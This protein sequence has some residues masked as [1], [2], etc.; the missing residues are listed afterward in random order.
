MLKR[1]LEN[2]DYSF[3]EIGAIL[4]SVGFSNVNY[5]IEGKEIVTNALAFNTRGRNILEDSVEKFYFGNRG[6]LRHFYKGFQISVKYYFYKKAKDKVSFQKKDH[7][8][9]ITESFQ[10]FQL[11]MDEGKIDLKVCNKNKSFNFQN[12]GKHL[13]ISFLV[14]DLKNEY[15]IEPLTYKSIIRD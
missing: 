14:M 9:L 15:V 8:E 4:E 7:E 13:A 6:L 1:L 10:R 5:K 2:T 3:E 12:C 11:L